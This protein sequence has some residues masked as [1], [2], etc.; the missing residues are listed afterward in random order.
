[1]NWL[2]N[3]SI[4]Y[5]IL[6]TP[7]LGIVL[8]SSYLTFNFYQTSSNAK[9]LEQSLNH[10]LPVIENINFIEKELNI[11][12]ESFSNAVSDEDEDVLSEVNH[13]SSEINKRLDMLILNELPSA[14]ELKEQFNFYILE[15]MSLSKKMIMGDG[16]FSKISQKITLVQASLGKLK[17]DL[18]A[19]NKNAFSNLTISVKDA[20]ERSRTTLNVG[21]LMALTTILILI[22]SMY[23]IISLVMRNINNLIDSFKDIAQGEGDLTKRLIKSSNDEF[24]T[25]VDWFNTFMSKLHKSIEQVVSS[26]EPLSNSSHQ[27][28]D[29]TDTTGVIVKKQVDT[30]KEVNI[31]MAEMSSTVRS[32]AQNAVQAADAAQVASHKATSNMEVSQQT[33]TIIESLS[34]RIENAAEVVTG[35]E[36]NTANVGTVL[37]V[38]RGI[39]DQTNLLALNAAIEAARAGEFGRGFAV[40]AEEVRN[41]AS[42]TQKSTEEI[43]VMITEL[44][45]SASAAVEVMEISQNQAKGA[46]T[47]VTETVELL[48]EIS[49]QIGT[50]SDINVQI[51]SATEEQEYTTKSIKENVVDIES[52]A[53]QTADSTKTI[54]ATSQLI[55]QMSSTLDEV[56]TQF[57][58]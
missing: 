47:S 2:K 43:Q 17:S 15:S 33:I 39:A 38:I 32:I 54:L 31:A 14:S 45:Q 21:L 53:A 12:A 26:V 10:N 29:I 5:K 58:V 46:V 18:Q 20:T 34:S 11:I 37:D 6:L 1:M 52:L 13:S 23:V 3:L 41:L 22:F 56:A 16:D 40:V 9:N 25:L 49:S 8:F 27:L 50:I 44:Q 35:L 42:K 36:S 48:H 19:L 55:E 57:K 30:S 28:H 4:R 24:G 7:I 51:A